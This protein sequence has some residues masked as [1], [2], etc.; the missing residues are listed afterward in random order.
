[1]L[2]PNLLLVII[3]SHRPYKMQLPVPALDT[4]WKFALN[5]NIEWNLAHTIVW[6]PNPKHWHACHTS[7]LILIDWLNIFILSFLTST[8]M[9]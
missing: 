9:Q 8:G 6:R 4:A 2:P 1:M 3:A 7:D 5:K